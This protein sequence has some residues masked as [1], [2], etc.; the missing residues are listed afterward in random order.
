MSYDEEATR[1]TSIL[2]QWKVGN[3]PNVDKTFWSRRR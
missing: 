2:T 1:M 3:T